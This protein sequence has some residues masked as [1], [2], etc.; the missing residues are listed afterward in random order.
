MLSYRFLLFLAGVTFSDSEGLSV[1]QPC[2]RCPQ[3]VSQLSAC[4]P[5]QDTWCDCGRNYFLWNK[6]NGSTDGL[7]APC[8]VCGKGEG[9]VQACGAAGDTL[10]QP[11]G[12]GTFSETKSSVQSCSRCSSCGDNKVEIRPCQANSD[13]LCMGECVHEEYQTRLFLNHSDFL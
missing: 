8:K 12:P 4:T 3:G 5:I 6:G 1:C 10:C 2:S 7:C 13:T 9:V 11:C